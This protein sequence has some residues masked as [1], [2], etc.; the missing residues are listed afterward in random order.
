MFVVIDYL[1]VNVLIPVVGGALVSWLGVWLFRVVRGRPERRYGRWF[2]ERYGTYWNPYLDTTEKL[3]LDRT[4]IPLSLVDDGAG[5]ADPATVTAAIADPG[6]GNAIVVGGAGSGKTTM[7]QA[8]GVSLLAGPIA[9]STGM[10]VPAGP[11]AGGRGEVPFFVAVRM[12]AAA[13]NRGGLADY[14]RTEVLSAGAGLTNE[15]ARR[16]LG[17]LLR[18]RRC[19]VLLDG[20]D[21]VTRA[22]YQAVR[23]A[24]YR[25]ARDHGA[26]LPTANAR[27]V[28]TSRH[29]NFLRIR[30]DWVTGPG[31]LV[32]DR[33][34]ALAPLRDEEILGYLNRMRDRFA[35]PDGP[36]YFMAAVRASD[37]MHL[38]RTPLLL[39]M[40]VGLYAGREFFE[41]PHSIAELYD[42]MI[43]EMLTRHTFRHGEERSAVANAFR[44][45]DKARLLR[46]LALSLAWEKGFGPFRRTAV[47]AVARTLRPMLLNVPPGRV[48]AFVDEVIER[49]GLLSPVVEDSYEFAHRSIQEHLV[50]SELLRT[51]EEGLRRLRER[52]TDRDWRQVVVF[53]TAAADQRV[54]S[55]LLTELADVDPV[56]AG[57]CLAGADCLDSNALPILDRLAGLLRD[58]DRDLA[59]PAMAALLSASTSPR[60]TVQEAA[61]DLIYRT[62]AGVADQSEALR[63]LGGDA[64][65]V[66]GVIS[67][68]VDRAGPAPMGR[69][70]VAELSAIV[71][72]DPRLVAPA[73]RALNDPA[74]IRSIDT[75]AEADEATGR[76]VDR[77]LVLAMDPACC[78]ELQRQPAR[79]PAFATAD[80][81]RQVYPFRGGVDPASNLV[82]LLCW[83]DEL[84]VDAA[85]P[86]RFLAAKRADRVA[87]ARMEADRRRTGFSVRLPGLRL[88]VATG[89]AT[90]RVLGVALTAIALAAA[91]VVGVDARRPDGVLSPPV[92]IGAL[93]LA[94]I[95]LALALP[96]LGLRLNLDPRRR[97]RLWQPN[98]FVDAYEDPASRHWLLPAGDRA[99]DRAADRAGDRAG[100]SG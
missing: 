68:L 80:R 64:E 70:L 3:R 41:I 18:Q 96:M 83:A 75:G 51:G 44:G 26:D 56:L 39:S 82:T 48:D 31:R 38:H 49:S 97:L 42:T 61:R 21:E 84:K 52:A 47:V 5:Q 35:R 25:F 57:G 59:L 60:P 46:E 30:D 54:V 9:A 34:Y 13:L 33:V 7:L 27:L 58:G 90:T 40:S 43:R 74:L 93:A 71:P 14:L 50:A 22:D 79:A 99:A 4:Y 95:E 15:E 19:V 100:A 1:L 66:L 16:F 89:A 6:A 87:W 28:I 69:A 73:W 72:D 78:D 98:P 45:E 8:Y 2:V 94:V 53:F 81:R 29:H 86:N 12:L 24:V 91:G 10:R 11:I 23:D 85:R 65:A 37:T 36:E 63:P 67:M 92:R 62:L 88:G 76:L 32:A 77:L 17:Q 55:P 20:L